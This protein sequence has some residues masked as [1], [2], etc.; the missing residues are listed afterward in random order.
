LG[1]KFQ[2]MKPKIPKSDNKTSSG[3]PRSKSSSTPKP[4]TKN[5]SRSSSKAN[6]KSALDHVKRS[7]LNRR[8]NNIISERNK[9]ITS[10]KEM[11]N[12]YEKLFSVYSDGILI[13]NS[14]TKRVIDANDSACKLFGY[15]KEE[16]VQLTIPEISL[17]PEKTL[18]QLEKTIKDELKT[19]PL[20][21]IKPKSGGSVPTEITTGVFQVKNKNYVFAIFRDITQQIKDQAAIKRK[22][23]ELEKSNRSLKEFVSIASHDLQ[24]PLRKIISFS[25]RLEEMELNLPVESQGY[26]SRMHKIAF[27]MQ[28]LL[29]DLL[30]FSQVSAPT[31]SV[32][33]IDLN[34]ILN[35]VL[36]DMVLPHQRL[37]ES[38]E[39]GPLPKLEANVPQMRQLFQNLISN[40]IKFHKEGEPLKIKIHGEPITKG[41]WKIFIKDQGIG[42]KEKHLEKIFQPFE[43]LHG[44]SEY[45]GTGMGLAICKKIVE[46]HGGAITAESQ[47]GKGACFIFILPG[48]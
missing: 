48:K 46:G 12:K 39:I 22:S 40:S 43:R 25:A 11:G 31:D 34:I 19:I 9:A 30:T 35:D 20:S 28:D 36:E 21:F 38:I 2:P 17:E 42:F 6:Q 18:G 14:E 23:I 47:P 4:K 37:K 41:L 5:L 33:K 3:S 15:S 45:E 10:L 1:P 32:Q 24:A 8:V 13:F 7:S 44:S 29:N 27:R 16:F 26:L